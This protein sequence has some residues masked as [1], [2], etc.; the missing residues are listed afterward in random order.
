MGPFAALQATAKGS[1]FLLKFPGTLPEA[2]VAL[3]ENAQTS[4]RR[5]SNLKSAA[6]LVLMG[7]RSK[8]TQ[9]IVAPEP[10]ESNDKKS[11]KEKGK[12][13]SIKFE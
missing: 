1:R 11:S 3:R 5:K 2:F 9:Q 10:R 4:T 13:R 8:S 7:N 6:G 12:R